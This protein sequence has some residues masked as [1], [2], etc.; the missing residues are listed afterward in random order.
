MERY[1]RGPY[2]VF[3]PGPFL[4]IEGLRAR[5]LRFNRLLQNAADMASAALLKVEMG[6]EATAVPFDMNV[7]AELIGCPVLFHEEVE[8]LPVYP[9]GGH[10]SPSPTRKYRCLRVCPQVLAA[11]DF[12]Q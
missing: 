8:G 10:L 7:E 1:R 4:P 5:G 11:L 12:L 2:P 6:F 9:T 3:S